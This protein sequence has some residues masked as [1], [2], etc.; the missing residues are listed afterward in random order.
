MFRLFALKSTAQ[1]L[2]E[3]ENE[4][5]AR[6][7]QSYTLVFT[8]KE[9]MPNAAEITTEHINRLTEAD[10]R[11]LA[12]CFSVLFYEDMK[13]DEKRL[14]QKMGEQIEVLEEELKKQRDKLN[15]GNT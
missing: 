8:E 2:K 13:K 6:A 7:T 14:S 5:F 3:A 4:R 11:W 9:S 15:E 10:K 1:T 12:D